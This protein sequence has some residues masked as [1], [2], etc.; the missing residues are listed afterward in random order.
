MTDSL[1]ARLHRQN[2]RPAQ[3]TSP[4]EQLRQR[5]IA[6]IGSAGFVGS[7]IL[8]ALTDFHGLRITALVRRPPQ[9]PDPRVRYIFADITDHLSLARALEGV[10]VVVHAASYTGSDERLSEA[11]N[12]VGTDNVLTAC[13]LHKIQ[14][15]INIST[16]GVYGPGPFSDIVEDSREPN[17]V[18]LLSATKAAADNLVRSH[19]GTTVRP[20][21]IYGP[22]DRWFLPGLQSILS[23][24]QAWVEEGE[25]LLSVISVAELG[26]LIAELART[27]STSD[28]GA[29]YHAARPEPETVHGVSAR[30][31]GIS[32]ALPEQ[33]YTYTE[34]IARSDEFGLSAR[35]IDLVGRDHSINSNQLWAR[36]QRTPGSPSI[37][38]RA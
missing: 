21:F 1:P 29:L 11:I 17:P 9:A 37:D 32:F 14:H 27:Y 35:Q 6:V 10:D 31:A 13:S 38:H 24:T 2:P 19:G 23:A 28:H 33:S 15:V 5:S 36:T 18:T 26:Q 4:G 7:A 25:A 30:L 22:G 20:G 3:F 12:Y 16:I 34:A 8:R